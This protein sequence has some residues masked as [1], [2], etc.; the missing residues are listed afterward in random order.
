MLENGGVPVDLY[1]YFQRVVFDLILHLTFGSRMGDVGDAFATELVRSLKSLTDIRSSTEDFSHYVPLLRVIPRGQTM[2]VKSERR[3]R[4]QIDH[5]YAQYLQRTERGEVV[6]CIVS[7]LGKEKLT[8]NELRGT[9]VSLHQAAPETVA[10]AMC[11]ACGWLATPEGQAY[12]PIVLKA[13]LNGYA[14]DR[15]RAWDMAFREEKVSLVVS[16]YKEALRCWAPTP[17]AQGRAT[18]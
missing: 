1:V 11:Q 6:N 15:D 10:S 13:I 7:S 9:C 18:V 4:R 16:M 17:F 8:L 5:L 3:R 2:V 12:Q 14:G